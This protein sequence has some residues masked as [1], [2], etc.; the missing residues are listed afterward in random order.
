M[1]ESSKLT[2]L[3]SPLIIGVDLDGVCADFY[4]RMREI[5]AEW[6]ETS[7]DRLPRQVSYGLKEWGI[8]SK[9]Q[10]ESLHRFAVTQR[11]LFKTLKMIPGA[12]RY[13]R[14]LSDEGCRIRIITYRLFIQYFHA[15]AVQQTIEWLDDN[16]I[17]YWDLCFMKDKDQVGANVYIEDNPENVKKL[18]EQGLE[19]ICFGNSTNRY[20]GQPKATNWNGV[21]KIIR[22]SYLRKHGPPG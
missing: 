16:G 10:Y 19:T 15:T 18:R 4:A 9:E 8:D 7:M 14:K 2:R 1:K 20:I 13:L 3:D 11:D 21:Y 22:H 6:F 5:A 17:P 12:R